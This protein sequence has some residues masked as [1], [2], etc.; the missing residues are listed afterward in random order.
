EEALKK[1]KEW[2]LTDSYI[3]KY[4]ASE[5]T[6]G[7]SLSMLTS[8]IQE[9]PVP[10]FVFKLN[11]DVKEAAK[12]KSKYSRYEC[13]AVNQCNEKQFIEFQERILESWEIFDQQSWH[14]IDAQAPV[15]QKLAEIQNQLNI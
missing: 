5:H 7:A 15:K 2:I 3:Y 13:G 8:L 11:I 12:R 14:L 4:F 6:A 9:F 1:G 10:D